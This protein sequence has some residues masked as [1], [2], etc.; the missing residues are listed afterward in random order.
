M[1]TSLHPNND[2]IGAAGIPFPPEPPPRR[3]PSYVTEHGEVRHR[4]PLC[5]AVRGR[6]YVALGAET[7]LYAYGERHCDVCRQYDC[8]LDGTGWTD[9]RYRQ[10]TT[11]DGGPQT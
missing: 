11:D 5:P 1:S 10:P 8:R 2:R 6:V 3:P 7:A 9:P 4:T